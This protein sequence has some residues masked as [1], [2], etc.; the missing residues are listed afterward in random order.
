MTYKLD[1]KSRHND[2]TDVTEE[3]P[4]LFTL[5]LSGNF[6]SSNSA[7]EQLFGY[8]A[9]EMRTMNIAE[10]VAP[11]FSHYLQGQM[12]RTVAGELGAVYEIE[13][14]T[15][16]GQCLPLEISTRLIIRNGSPFELEGI[17]FPLLNTIG[18]RPRCLDEEFWIGP[19]LNGPTALTFNPTR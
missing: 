7:A 16:A 13:I 4:I 8:S 15:K 18:G 12:A 2:V 1:R 5:D 6:K 3:T 9:A 19:G 11:G 10:L 14:Y 17:A